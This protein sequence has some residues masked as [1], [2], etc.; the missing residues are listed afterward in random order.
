MGEQVKDWRDDLERWAFEQPSKTALVMAET[1]ESW[2]FATLDREADAA[3]GWLLS[4]GMPDG[5]TIALIIENRR[6]LIALWYAARR[7]GFYFA[8]ISTLSS[9]AEIAHVIADSE[10]RILIASESYAGV[11]SHAISLLGDSAPLH[12]IML[13]T[14]APGFTGLAEAIADVGPAKPFPERSVGREFLYSSGTTGKPKGVRRPLTSYSERWVVPRFEFHIRAIFQMTQDMVYLS[15]APLYHSTSRFLARTLDAGGTAIVM[16]RFD[17]AAALE[18]IERYQVTHSLWV[19]TMF[20]RLLDLPEADRAERDIS[21]LQLALHGAAPCPP[22]VKVAMLEWWG[23]VIEE[24]YGGTEN[25]GL[26]HVG[27]ADWRTHPG[28]VGRCVSGDIHILSED[29]LEAELP[30]GEIG[31]VYFSGGLPFTYHR[32]E[33]KSRAA[34][35]RKGWGTYGDLG[36][37]DEHGYLYLS[38][39]RTD[40]IITGGVNVYPREVEDVLERHA[41]VAEA[42]VIGLAHVDLGQMVVAVVRLRD[43]VLP[44]PAL[45]DELG[46]YCRTVLSSV[47]CPRQI[48]FADSLPVNENGKLLKRVLRDR[49]AHLAPT[50]GIPA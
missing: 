20:A 43:A 39:R 26:T 7:A 21:S 27:A 4:L 14:V 38:D 8:P 40:L 29:G 35:S 3:R 47:K 11:A 46:A 42:A 31:L 19:P 1:G 18:A 28:S 34:L 5:A 30:T 36:H 32:D 23:D 33:A 12:Q 44:T 50:K 17:A 2:D 22:A 48:T 45:A 16:G 24:F 25:V 15:L 6:E 13:G 10:A 9:A 37:V 49:Y 41:V